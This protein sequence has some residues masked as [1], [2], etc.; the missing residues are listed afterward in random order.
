MWCVFI[1]SKDEEL[2]ALNKTRAS[3]EVELNLQ[4]RALRTDRG[5]EFTSK[6]FVEF[7]DSLGIKHYLTAPYSPQ[8]NGVVERRNQTVIGMARSLLKIK[9]MPW[10]FFWEKQCQQQCIC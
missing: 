5:G 6:K 4:A 2:E 9:G 8:Q 1:K 10:F 3:M 7:C